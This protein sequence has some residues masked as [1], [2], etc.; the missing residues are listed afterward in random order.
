MRPYASSKFR[1][2]LFLV[3]IGAAVFAMAARDR[4]WD[5]GL[6]TLLWLAVIASASYALVLVWRHYRSLA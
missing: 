6:G 3:L 5:T 2:L 4:L 1:I